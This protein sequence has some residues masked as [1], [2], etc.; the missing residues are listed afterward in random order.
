MCRIPASLFTLLC[1]SLALPATAQADRRSFTRTYEYTTMPQGQTELEI[2]STQSVNRFTEASPRAFELQLEIEHGITDRFDLGLY[3]VFKQVSAADA[4]ASQAFHFSDLKLRGRYRFAE[5]GELPVDLLA[6]LE[7]AKEFGEGVYEAEG[8]I[9]LARDVGQVLLAANL[10]TEVAF[11]P[12]TTETEVELGWAVGAA[13]EVMPALRLGVET[14]GGFEAAEPGELAASVGPTISWA[15]SGKLWVAGTAGF[16]VTDEADR[17][18]G[19]M[20]LGLD[21]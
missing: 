15:S 1:A 20:I 7:L 2:Y 17:F 14:Y 9:I 6:Y 10:I 8:K 4:M 19:R 16:G 13:V 5:R 11:G 3:H 18:S 12:D 21:L